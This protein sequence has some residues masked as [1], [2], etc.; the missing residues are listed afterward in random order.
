MKYPNVADA[1]SYAEKVVRGEILVGKYVRLACQRH[2]DDLARVDDEDFPYYFDHKAA[3]K[4]LTF[5]QMLPHVK[6]VWARQGKLITL[7]L[8]QK[9]ALACP[10]GWK[11]KKNGFRRFRE[12]YDEIPRKNGKSILAAA[13]GLI[14]FTFD[15]EFG[16]EVYSGATTEKQAWE[17]FRPA[18]LMVVRTPELQEAFGIE[19]CAS[20]MHRLEDGSRFE[21]LIGNPGD[22]SSPSLALIDEYHEHDS[23]DLYETMVTGMDAREQPLTWIIT[24]AGSNISGPCYEKRQQ[25][26]EMLEGVLPDDELFALIFTLDEGDDWTTETALRKANPNYGISIFEDGLLSKQRKAAQHASHQNA[27]KTKHL[28]IW[29]NAKSAY[30]NIEDWRK[31]E[32]K[33]LKIEDFYFHECLPSLDMASKLD[34]LAYV[35]CF[36]ETINGKRHYYV[37]APQFHMPEDTIINCPDRGMQQ[38]YEKWVKLGVLDLFDG[39][40]N[41]FGEIADYVIEDSNQFAI[42]EVPHDPWG[43]FEIAHKLAKAG[44]TPVM[45]KQTTENLSTAMKEMKAAMA[46]GRLHHDGNILL[47]WM[48]SNVVAKPDARDNVYPRKEKDSNKIDGAIALMMS[49]LRSM[50]EPEPGYKSPYE[51]EAYI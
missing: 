25:A 1:F 5:V 15:N 2:I 4:I 28:N 24:T 51:D 3:E 9:F 46:S 39:A 20:N 11:K 42:R 29:T 21:P 49:I 35:R 43:A 34:L 37:V 33:S 23:S 30:F 32:D 44:L 50:I 17:V 47:T 22:G 13:V 27:F 14:G 41:D 10:F 31:C 36:P 7:E 48:I 40:E 8:W 45:I 38:R 12:V 6:G 19:V 26:I 16:A 18:R